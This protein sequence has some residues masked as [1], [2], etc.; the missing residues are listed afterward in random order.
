MFPDRID[1]NKS[2]NIK[3]RTHG[4]RH[5]NFAIKP[6]GASQGRIDGPR[7]ISGPHDHHVPRPSSP[8]RRRRRRSVHKCQELRD[9]A[10]LML[11]LAV[12]TRTEGVQLVQEDEY[13]ESGGGGGGLGLGKGVAEA[14]LG[15]SGEGAENGGGRDG[16]YLWGAR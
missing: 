6:A 10:R 15:L 7:P 8:P 12:A 5:G 1:K 13:G 11:P 16:D 14:P 4:N 9:D 3:H 2:H